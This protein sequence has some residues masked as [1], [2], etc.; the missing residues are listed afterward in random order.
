MND[1]KL[2]ELVAQFC[3]YLNASFYPEWYE[4]IFQKMFAPSFKEHG[5]DSVW[6]QQNGVA[7]NTPQTSISFKENVPR[8]LD[9]PDRRYSVA[10]A[11]VRFDPVRLFFCRLIAKSRFVNIVDKGD[12]SHRN[13]MYNP[14]NYR[15]V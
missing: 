2:H 13:F 3:S 5:L 7:A 15:K 6:F 1:L 4:S 10:R 8:A 12:N 14:I 11:L 9:L